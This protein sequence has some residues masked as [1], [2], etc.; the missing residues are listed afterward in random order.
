MPAV[1]LIVV[2][3]QKIVAHDTPRKSVPFYNV[4][5]YNSY[6]Q[7]DFELSLFFRQHWEDPELHKIVQGIIK[8]D[9][10]TTALDPTL[11]KKLWRPDLLFKNEELARMHSVPA[12]QIMLQIS[13]EGVV[14]L[15]QH[16]TLKLRCIFHLKLFPFDTQTCP[17][18]IQS[19]AFRGDQIQLHWTRRVRNF[20]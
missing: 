19:F 1:V 16:V 7:M 13:P 4:L 8:S 18:S 20:F 5:I 14:T 12:G 10:D 11:L 17:I 6:G 3:V 2:F 15:S 9:T